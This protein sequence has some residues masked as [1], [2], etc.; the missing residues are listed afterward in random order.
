MR[1][2][3]TQAPSDLIQSVSR[4]LRILEAVGRSKSGLTVK[5]IARRCDLGL[6]TAYHLVRTLTYEGYLLRGADGVHTPGLEVADRFRELAAAV[7]PPA[8][9][10]QGLRRAAGETGYSH[11]LARFVSGKVAITGVAEGPRSPHL[12]DLVVGFDEAAHA[13]A[14][15]KAL[16]STLDSGRRRRYLSV[17]GMRPYTRS[18]I[19]DRE[20]LEYDLVGLRSRG[21]FVE[22]GQYREGVACV[23]TVIES[24]DNSA[25]RM[26]LASAMSAQEFTRQEPAVLHRLSGVARSL[27]AAVA[28]T[29]EPPPMPL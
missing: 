23:A 27:A 13:T 1:A 19:V 26:V 15:G 3:G 11:Y 18:T 29:P 10:N 25:P 8:D 20:Q 16:L 6:S 7:E 28:N 4:A 22:L 24:R 17:V 12:E 2:D 9:T 21:A 5:Q 14:V